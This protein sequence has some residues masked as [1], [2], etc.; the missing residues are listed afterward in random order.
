MI[1][2]GTLLAINVVAGNPPSNALR[3]LPDPMEMSWAI[4][5]VLASLVTLIGLWTHIRSTMASGM[6]AFGCILGAYAA[7]VMAVTPWSRGGTVAG[8]LFIIGGVCLIRGWWLKEEE[9]AQ[10]KENIRLSDTE[11]TDG[12]S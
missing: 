1:L 8:F 4:L 9:A 3:E 5:M 7:A 2:W 11:E 12:R 10:I 6:Q